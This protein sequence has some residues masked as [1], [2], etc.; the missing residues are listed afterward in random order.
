[1]ESMV[2]LEK[3]FQNLYVQKNR[4]GHIKSVVKYFNTAQEKLFTSKSICRSHS[5]SP[6]STN[7]RT[8]KNSETS[9]TNYDSLDQNNSSFY[10]EWAIRTC[11]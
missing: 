11:L 1:M 5:S 2:N 4:K 6:K 9:D 8:W 7:H 10:N 3:E